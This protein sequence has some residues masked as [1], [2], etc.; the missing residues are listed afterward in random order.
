M[1]VWKDIEGYEDKY[2]ISNL[3]R[4]KSLAD[5]KL[6][7]RELI[8]KPRIGKNGYLYVN[9]FK[10]SKGKT[11]KIHRL[12]AETFIPNPDNLPQVNHIDGNKLN[13]SIDNLEWVTASENVKHALRIGLTTMPSG[14]NNFM[15]GKHGKDNPHS[16]TVYQYD[17][18]GNF[19]KEWVNVKE[20]A[21]TLKITHI[22]ACCRGERT[23]AGEFIWKYK[24]ELCR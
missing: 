6:I 21:E 19:I 13:N 23:R 1:E 8:R 2:Q 12:V 5:N 14:K 17:L 15:Y 22:D 4:V 11:K 20:A 7:E 18:K 9:L 24:E 10:G 3:G 16:R